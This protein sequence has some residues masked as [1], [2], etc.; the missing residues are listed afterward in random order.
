ML[1]LA[2]WLHTAQETFS[3]LHLGLGLKVA[4]YWRAARPGLCQKLLCFQGEGADVSALR[5]RQSINKT[6][7]TPDALQRDLTA[8]CCSIF[9]FFFSSKSNGE[10]PVWICE[11]TLWNIQRKAVK[12]TSVRCLATS[13][14]K[15]FWSWYMRA[16]SS[17]DLPDFFQLLVKFLYLFSWK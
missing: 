4:H 15:P 10:W 13:D 3:L 14:W 8:R 5:A 11:V 1:A 7:R 6:A 2:Q 16:P 17:S 9:F 12:H